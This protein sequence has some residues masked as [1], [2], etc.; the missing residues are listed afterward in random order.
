[1]VKMGICYLML[2][3]VVNMHVM[4]CSRGHTVYNAY[5]MIIII[6]DMIMAGA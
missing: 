1:M 6:D 4:Q 5:E 2:Q 3:Q